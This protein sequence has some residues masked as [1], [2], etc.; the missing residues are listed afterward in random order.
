V[1]A[2]TMATASVLARRMPFVDWAVASAARDGESHN[3][4]MHVVKLLSTGVLAAAIDGLGHGAEAAAA[5][6]RAVQTLESD[7]GE[8]VIGLSR[9]CHQALIGTRGVTM[10]LAAFNAADDTMTWL[11]IGNVEGVLV[12]ADPRTSRPL[13]TIL[14]RAGVIGLELPRLQASVTTVAP[15]DVVVL[16][17]DGINRTFLGGLLRPLDSP[18][19]LADRILRRHGKGT[20]DALVLVARYRGAEGGP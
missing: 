2:L 11:A 1:G 14:P 8:S 7:L 19:Q 12:R 15:G 18:Q 5:A 9:S 17:T 13:E 6:Q 16:A 3:G 10:S 20:D 4:D